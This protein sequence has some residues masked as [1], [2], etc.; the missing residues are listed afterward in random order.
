MSVWDEVKRSVDDIS[1]VAREVANLLTEK[2]DELS[3]EGRLKLEVFNLQRQVKSREIKLGRRVFFLWSDKKK[4]VPAEDEEA[5]SHLEALKGL[6]E[7]IGARQGEV[8][9]IKEKKDGKESG[10]GED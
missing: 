9:A 2:T 10:G 1:D 3:R 5:R 6:W 7:E 8:E 4:A